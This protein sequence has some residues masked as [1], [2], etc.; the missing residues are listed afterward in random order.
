MKKFRHFFLTSA[1]LLC[2]GFA[3]A[4]VNCDPWITAIYKQLYNRQPSSAE[5]NIQNYNNGS[6]SNYQQLTDYIKNYQ[7]S[8][9]GAKLSPSMVTGDPWIMEIY[10]KLYGRRP[11]S[12]ELN[13]KMYN[14]GSWSSYEQLSG[15]IQQFQKSLSDQGVSLETALLNETYNLVA[16]KKDGKYIAANILENKGGSVVAS[17][18]GNV[19]AAGGGNVIAAG[20]G[21][22]VSAGGGNVVA[23]GGGNVIAAGGMNLR[24]Y[25]VSSTNGQVQFLVSA[26]LLGASF[27]S[28]YSVQSG[29]NLQIK[30]SGSG[31]IIFK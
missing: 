26:D 3:F 31:S 2:T 17:G 23:A 20:G 30:T 24:G 7:S 18:G 16:I 27:S 11:N 28:G 15:Y 10:Q 13:I 19:I 29:S 5:C 1:L 14:N 21:N 25:R 8:R 9:S 6:W 4:Q 22:V 12:F